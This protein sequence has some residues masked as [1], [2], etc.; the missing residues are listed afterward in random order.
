MFAHQRITSVSVALGVVMFVIYGGFA[1]GWGNALAAVALAFW[2]LHWNDSNL[3][4]VQYPAFAVSRGSA[5][6]WDTTLRS[7]SLTGIRAQG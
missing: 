4:V 3:A 1:I 6:D 5:S 2:G 7:R